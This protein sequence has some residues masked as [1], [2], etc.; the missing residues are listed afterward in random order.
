MGSVNCQLLNVRVVM[1]SG[2]LS[3]SVV[4]GIYVQ[5]CGLLM[6][7]WLVSVLF[8]Q[9][10]VFSLIVSVMLSYELILD[11][12]I[13]SIWIRQ[14][15]IQFIKLQQVNVLSVVDNDIQISVGV[16]VNSW[17]EVLSG[18]VFFWVLLCVG[19]WVSISSSI[20]SKM[21]GVVIIKKVIC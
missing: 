10:F 21:F 1:R 12:D 18:I 2:F 9:I 20:D 6:M 14:V 8:V 19:L 17:I 7:K 5:V 13:L 11:S 4:V 15:V 16:V 3:V